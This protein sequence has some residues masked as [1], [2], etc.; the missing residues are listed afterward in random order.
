MNSVEPISAASKADVAGLPCCA[1]APG[2]G[3]PAEP[4]IRQEAVTSGDAQPEPFPDDRAF[5]AML[6]RLTG[7]ISPVALSLAYM[8]WVSHLA[9]APQRQLDRSHAALRGAKQFLEAALHFSSPQHGPWSLIQSR[10][11]DALPDRNGSGRR[12]I[13]WR[14]LF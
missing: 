6:A 8:D 7:G 1:H 3:L 2:Y 5:H 12:S 13:C 9:A 10:R 14:R 4:G 11:I